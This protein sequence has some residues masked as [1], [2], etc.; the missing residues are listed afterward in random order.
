[1]KAIKPRI[2]TVMLETVTLHTGM[3]CHQQW[4]V[5]GNSSGTQKH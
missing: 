3:D 2:I 4:K 1:M 5:Q